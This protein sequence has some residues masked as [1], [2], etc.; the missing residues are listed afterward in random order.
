MTDKDSH[1]WI[2]DVINR[3]PSELLPKVPTWSN[4]LSAITRLK[5]ERAIALIEMKEAKK[6]VQRLEKRASDLEKKLDQA[7]N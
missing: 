4:I 1:F 3:L 6:A 5:T 7:T 2:K